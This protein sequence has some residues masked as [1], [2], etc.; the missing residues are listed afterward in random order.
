[1]TLLSI[2]S[3]C[4]PQ[5][6]LITSLEVPMHFCGVWLEC[7]NQFVQYSRNRLL[8]QA[9]IGFIMSGLYKQLTNHIAAF[10]VVYGIFLSLGELG[11]GNCTFILASKSCPTAVRGQFF[12]VAAAIGKVGAFVG[13]WVF[14]PMIDAFGG[15]NSDRGNTGP[16]WVGSGI[17]V[18][19]AIIAFF[20]VKPLDKD[21]MVEED[22]Q[23][24][25]YLEANGYDTS[26]MGLKGGEEDE[27][28]VDEKTDI[29]AAEN[30]SRIERI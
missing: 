5:R 7:C 27:T 20:F 8:S 4:M 9:V 17:A 16:F 15:P 13:T 22:K 28:S 30:G 26:T 11:P 18:L 23:F 19:S 1:M 21:G 2:P 25:A 10:A 3:V 29:E 6:W 24:R 14:P 12:G